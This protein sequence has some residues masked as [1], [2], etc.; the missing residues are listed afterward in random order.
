MQTL[1]TRIGYWA[2]LFWAPISFLIVRLGG[3]MEADCYA[4]MAAI[5]VCSLAFHMAAGSGVPPLQR[6]IRWVLVAFPACIVLQIVPLPAGLLA[7]VAPDKAAL[8]PALAR[9]GAPHAWM[10]I[11]FVPS[12]TVF[13]LTRFCAGVSLFLAARTLTS[14]APARAWRLTIPLITAAVVEAAAGLV[15]F[16]TLVDTGAHGTYGNHNHYACLL[17]MSLPFAA[18]FPF[19]ILNGGQSNRAGRAVRAG[20]VFAAAI[21]ILAGIAASLSR[22]GFI[23]ALGS[24]AL[25]AVLSPA[26]QFRWKVR[27]AAATVAVAAGLTVFLFVPPDLLLARYRDISSDLR[28][29]LWKDTSH[30]IAANP[31]FGAGLGAFEPALYPYRTVALDNRLEYAHSD[32]LQILAETGVVGF[33]LIVILFAA[34][35]REAL[36]AVRCS[37]EAPLAVASV[38]ALAALLA[39]SAV[40]FNLYIPAN[41][42]A[43]AWIAGIAS[44]LSNS[45]K[46]CAS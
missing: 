28:P 29:A 34:L 13:Q 6:A 18:A 22:A 23:I 17:E 27:M 46:T 20:L 42:L 1:E 35:A 36:R 11:S 33:V 43:A 19:A 25:M 7:L 39:H 9:I 12:E 38:G 14:R 10:P 5:A 30:W 31:V 32:V 37:G 16:F 15:Q 3:V 41:A 26:R 8:G 45:R 24:L 21:L 2:V 4:G 40:D 44:G